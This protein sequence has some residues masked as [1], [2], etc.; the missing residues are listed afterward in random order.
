M[1]D[2]RLQGMLPRHTPHPSRLGAAAGCSS[3]APTT[4][5]ISALYCPGATHEKREL[6]RGTVGGASYQSSHWVLCTWRC[7]SR[8]A[9]IMSELTYSCFVPS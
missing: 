5:T 3:G 7:I 9:S 1:Q 6:K 4:T 2:E 8:T